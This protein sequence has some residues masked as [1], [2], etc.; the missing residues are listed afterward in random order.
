MPAIPIPL[1]WG[2][3]TIGGKNKANSPACG[4]KLEFLNPKSET[5]S[6]LVC[7]CK[8]N[9][10]SACPAISAKN[11]INVKMF[12][13]A[14]IFLKIHKKLQKLSKSMSKI[15]KHPA[16]SSLCEKTNPICRP[17]A[18]STRL[19]RPFGPTKD[20]NRKSAIFAEKWASCPS[21]YR[22]LFR[23]RRARNDDELSRIEYRRQAHGGASH[24]STN[25]YCTAF[26]AFSAVIASQ[27]LF[28]ISY[29]FNTW[30]FIRCVLN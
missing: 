20:K 6:E 22:P 25:H 30:H 26:S 23:G 16:S 11:K 2:C 21:V 27:G 13:N 7:I 5:R 14:Q 15:K 19:P 3:H 9:P 17:M 12:K 18:E 10:I 29:L 4:R 8:T 1:G 24:H 28:L